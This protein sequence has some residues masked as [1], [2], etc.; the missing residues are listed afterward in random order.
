MR[1]IL[2]TFGRVRIKR[3]DDRLTR[4][5]ATYFLSSDRDLDILL[6]EPSAVVSGKV[7]LDWILYKP[8]MSTSSKPTF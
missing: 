4:A 5:L 7:N 1:Y 3:S 6:G 8:I 2:G